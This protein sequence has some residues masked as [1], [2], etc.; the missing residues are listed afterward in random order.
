MTTLALV[1]VRGAA[2]HHYVVSPLLRAFGDD[3][4]RE[5]ILRDVKARV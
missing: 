3:E 2:V 4:I 1:L 5:A